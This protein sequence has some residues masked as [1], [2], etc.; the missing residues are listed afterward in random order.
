MKTVLFARAEKDADAPAPQLAPDLRA[1][2]R[3]CLNRQMCNGQAI[4]LDA[5]SA[6]VLTRTHACWSP[7]LPVTK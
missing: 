7:K 5:G 6:E 1:R 4:E 2:S 3:K